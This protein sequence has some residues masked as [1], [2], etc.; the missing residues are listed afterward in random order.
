MKSNNHEIKVLVVDDSDFIRKILTDILNSSK[1]I[2]VIGVAKNGKEAIKFIRL[3]KPDVVTMDIEMPILD[4]IGALKQIMQNHPVP[5]IMLSSLTSDGA[6]ATLKTLDIGAVDFIQ[7]PSS[8]FKINIDEFKKELIDKISA[9]SKVRLVR[10][11]HSIKT[12]KPVLSESYKIMQSLQKQHYFI[13]IGTSTGGPRALQ[14]VLTSIPK[15]ISASILIVQHMPPVFTKSL[16]E[17]LNNMCQITV[18]EAEDNERVL[19]GHAYIAPGNYHLEINKTSNEDV[20]LSLSTAQQVSGHRPSVDVLFKSVANNLKKNV[21]GV[22]MTGMGVD[23][24]NGIRELK[25][26]TECYIIAQDRETSVVY[27]MP[28]SAISTGV[29][30]D[31]VPLYE[32]TNYI[33]KRLGV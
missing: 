10:K 12:K 8:V 18:K 20:F 17:R 23:G 27:G 7:K 29:V 26:N 14:Y 15:D 19:L 30:D 22:I 13:L 5:V 1:T 6:D 31:I 21:I 33:L 25:E 11:K 3:L 16:A 32:I 2:K 4:G 9:A 28:G 24:A